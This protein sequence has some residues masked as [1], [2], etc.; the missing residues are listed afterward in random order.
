MM[1]RRQIKHSVQAIRLSSLIAFLI[2]QC[3][4]T[5][6]AL[7][8]SSLCLLGGALLPWYKVPPQ[9]ITPFELDFGLTKIAQG[10]A[11]LLSIACALSLWRIRFVAIARGCLWIG[12]LLFLLFPYAFTHLHPEIS[13]ITSDY[14]NQGILVSDSAELGI[15]QA[16]NSWK[17]DMKLATPIVIESSIPLEI[18]SSKFF[19]L[20]TFVEKA[21]LD[22]LRYGSSFF[23]FISAGWA[24]CAFG[25]FAAL[26]ATYIALDS[27]QRLSVLITDLTAVLPALA[28]CL[29]LSIG[30][31]LAA[32]IANYQLNVAFAKG[33]Y[34]TVV[35]ESQQLAKWYPLLKGDTDFVMRESKARYYTGQIE[36]ATESLALG[37]ALYQQGAMPEAADYLQQALTTR[38]QLYLAR[39]YLANTLV[40]QGVNQF[41]QQ[42]TS[43]AST[44]FQRALQVYP[45]HIEALYDLMIAK[46]VQGNFSD[47]ARLG[48]ELID[49]QTYFHPSVLGRAIVGQAH[50]H[51]AWR[52][53]KAGDTDAAWEQYFRSLDRDDVERVDLDTQD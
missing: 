5:R 33:Q 40:K 30:L 10:M 22:I 49:I 36:P 48:Q 13:F 7:L 12:L 27:R 29:I 43:T 39:G 8:G 41:N 16:Q 51:E 53:F 3:S 6:L 52:S 18:N 1:L 32:N 45:G 24:L 4:R 15:L 11:L 35:A 34:A 42:Q 38:P 50:L 26:N 21:F 25:I 19:N 28:L 23:I 46:A 14:F 37:I 20:S 47:S 44:Y 9:L 17:Q 31:S 2:A